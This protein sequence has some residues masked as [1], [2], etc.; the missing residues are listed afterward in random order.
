MIKLHHSGG[1][2]DHI[3]GIGFIVKEDKTPFKSR[4]A[5]IVL[6]Q[7]KDQYGNLGVCLNIPEHSDIELFR[8]PDF[9]YPFDYKNDRGVFMGSV[10]GMKDLLKFRQDLHAELKV[11][12]GYIGVR[13]SLYLLYKN[14]RPISTVCQLPRYICETASSYL[15]A[16]DITVARFLYTRDMGTLNKEISS[17]IDSLIFLTFGV[18]EKDEVEIL[19][20][21]DDTRWIGCD[22][23]D[24]SIPENK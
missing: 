22:P 3:N 18:F 13:A 6:Q 23:R 11:D 8:R 9:P 21:I 12:C 10:E 19:N 20:I 14:H 24:F 2:A 7:T 4:L 15:H 17:I 5:Q 16:F 1:I